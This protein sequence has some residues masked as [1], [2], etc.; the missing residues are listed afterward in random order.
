MNYCLN[1][2]FRK[3]DAHVNKICYTYPV[4]NYF[5]VQIRLERL[6]FLGYQITLD[7]FY[8]QLVYKQLYPIL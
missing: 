5:S 6:I 2:H 7:F 8:K 4:S 1:F 3:D